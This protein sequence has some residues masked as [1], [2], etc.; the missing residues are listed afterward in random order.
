MQVVLRNG[1]IASGIRVLS[2]IDK[3][4]K[5]ERDIAIFNMWLSCRTQGE[6]AQAFGIDQKTVSNVSGANETFRFVLNP[7]ELSEIEDE[8]ER[9]QEKWKGEG[10]S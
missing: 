4:D 9:W 7:G 8:E 6:I 10:S 5:E 1:D 3:D 2:R